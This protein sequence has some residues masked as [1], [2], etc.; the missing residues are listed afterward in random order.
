MLWTNGIAGSLKE[1]PHTTSAATFS[2]FFR[3]GDP[4]PGTPALT[5]S[6]VC[7]KAE[8]SYVL[9]SGTALLALKPGDPITIK[10]HRF[11]T[12][13]VED[14]HWEFTAEQKEVPIRARDVMTC[15][16]AFADGLDAATR[17]NE[18]ERGWV[19]LEDAA[20]RA[21]LIESFLSNW[22]EAGAQ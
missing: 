7:E 15:L 9:P 10:I 22:E 18:G 1:A 17:N 4:F 13:E 19:S 20:D 8:I 12:N 14:V 5:V 11:D 21:R 3:R 2:L 16:Y 6:I